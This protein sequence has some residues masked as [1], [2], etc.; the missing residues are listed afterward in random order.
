M[1]SMMK[2]ND[3]YALSYVLVVLLVL[4]A[5][6]LAVMTLSLNAVKRQQASIDQ[7][8][9]KYVAQGYVEQF[10]AQLEHADDNNLSNVL[11]KYS[12]DNPNADPNVHYE[13]HVNEDS[14][15]YTVVAVSLNT[16]VTAEISLDEVY[17]TIN[18][19]PIAP[20]EGN[21]SDDT[22][23]APPS[24]EEQTVVTGH[25]VTYLSYKTEILPDTEVTE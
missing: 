23:P 14:V 25:T 22:N 11:A 5:I 10:V 9:D 18:L 4:A 20:T 21:D 13:K 3:G 16:K 19:N 15:T 1:K 8:K 2:R 24:E 17:E 12:P 7:M 6:A